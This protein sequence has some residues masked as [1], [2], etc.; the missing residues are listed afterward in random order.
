MEHESFSRS[1]KIILSQYLN[2][3]KYSINDLVEFL[4]NVQSFDLASLD[5]DGDKKAF[6]INVYNGLT[7]Y[8]IVK[9]QLKKSVWEKEDFFTDELLKI[10]DFRFSL[11]AIEHGILR[12]NGPRK[13]DK[14]KQFSD[15]DSRLKLMLKN[16][17]FR[18]HFAL[19]CGSVSCPPIAYYSEVKIDEELSL[20]ESSFS[21]SEFVIDHANKHIECSAI[22][23][24]YRPDFGNHYLNDSVLSQY[25]V[26]ER[27]YVWKIQ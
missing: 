3:E 16:M 15:E 2:G 9:N 18:V 27:P 19:N 8:Q 22:F 20:A 24:W 6:W 12:K 10:G 17:D 23:V 25:T 11:D 21:S 7:N 13:K 1:A 4:E 5:N 26:N 14:P